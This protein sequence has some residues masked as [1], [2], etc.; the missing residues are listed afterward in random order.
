M[1][2]FRRRQKNITVV[3]LKKVEQWRVKYRWSPAGKTVKNALPARSNFHHELW[4]AVWVREFHAFC[5]KN[6]HRFAQRSH[7]DRALRG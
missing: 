4:L 5:V 1:S 3:E 2:A 6:T 7:I